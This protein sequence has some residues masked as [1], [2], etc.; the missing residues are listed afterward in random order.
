LF[1]AA[2]C[3]K[4]P[5]IDLPEAMITLLAAIL[6]AIYGTALFPLSLFVFCT[7]ISNGFRAFFA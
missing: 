5:G 2:T 1:T 4:I 6:V 7:G 3:P